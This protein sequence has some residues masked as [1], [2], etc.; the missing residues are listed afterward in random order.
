MSALIVDEA[1]VTTAVLAHL[2]PLLTPYAAYDAD[3][4]SRLDELPQ[5]YVEVSVSRRLADA[6]SRVGEWQGTNSFR[7]V[8]L[9]VAAVRANAANLR[10]LVRASFD[11]TMM[12][13]AGTTAPVTFATEQPLAPDEGWWSGRTEWTLTL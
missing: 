3:T 2:A 10:R 9:A 12:P 5:A 4:L 1:A 11:Q 6:P 7:V 13:C 8:I